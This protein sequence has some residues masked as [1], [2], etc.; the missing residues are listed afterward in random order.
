MTRTRVALAA[1]MV[2]VAACGGGPGFVA[3]TQSVASSTTERP[4]TTFRVGEIGQPPDL[5]VAAGDHELV[6]SP[7]A[8]CWFSEGQG[9]CADGAPPEP[10][11]SLTLESSAALSARF[12]LAWQLQATLF[13]GGG[14]C[15]GG[16]TLILDPNG[17]PVDGL[18]LAGTYEVEVFGRG[19]QGD[20]AFSFELITMDDRATP[21]LFVQS[22]W[23]PGSGEPDP[24]TTFSAQ[25]GN[26]TEQ[27]TEVTA[28]ATVTAA[29]GSA[30]EFELSRVDDSDCWASAI[31]LQGPAEMSSQVLELGLPPY[32]IVLETTVDGQPIVSEPIRWPD[33]YP[34]NGNE[35]SRISVTDSE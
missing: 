35:P 30:Q 18:R 31:A 16:Q 2:T 26:L 15:D 23:F 25:L 29:D 19:E 5:V 12:P 3:T 21:P 8:Y 4:S 28:T 33:D 6:L 22:Y 10:L 34:S 32:D 7:W 20:A 14:F 27:P 11:S 24:D 9:V 13:S 17:A 1:L